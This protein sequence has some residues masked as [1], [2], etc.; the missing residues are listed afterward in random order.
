MPRILKTLLKDEAIGGKLILAAA[1]LAL[2]IANT[3]LRQAYEAFWHQSLSLGVNQFD[4]SLDLRHWLSEG[5][6]ALFFLVVGLE[7]KREF[8][9]GQLR[10]FK[11]AALPIGAAIGGMVVP[12]A[13]FFAFNFDQAENINGWAIP[14]A[15]DIAFALGVM[16]LLGKRVSS[17]L[18]VFL[19][20]LAVVDDIGAIFIIALFYGTGFSLLPLLI[21]SGIGLLLLLGRKNRHM[22]LP[23]FV[24]LGLVMWAAVYKSGVHA[25]ITGAFL[26]LLAPLAASSRSSVAERLERYT[27]PVTTL[28]VVPLF[29]FASL[30]INLSSTSLSGEGPV[31]LMWGIIGGLVAG[32]VIGVVLASWLLVRLKVAKLPVNTTWLQLIGTGFLTGIGFTV[33]IFITEL[34]FESNPELTFAAKISILIAS[35]ISAVAGYLLLRHKREVQSLLDSEFK[36]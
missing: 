28:V 35:T 36:Q 13:F 31:R 34:A 22:S 17:S 19:L 15:T 23:L 4:I 6:M 20:T 10:E 14:I 27:I 26:G 3:P 8:V 2:V 25:S 33:S 30:G 24:L 16:S 5:L 11:A 32:K 29:A 9:K 21:A 12:A 18:K 7:I 1:V